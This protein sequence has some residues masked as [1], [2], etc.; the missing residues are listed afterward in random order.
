MGCCV[1]ME[2]AGMSVVQPSDS[3]STQ[4]LTKSGRERSR[5]RGRERGRGKMVGQRKGEGWLD[6]EH[7]KVERF[8]R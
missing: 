2:E 1:P 8:R 6:R 7:G 3:L 4:S 5:D